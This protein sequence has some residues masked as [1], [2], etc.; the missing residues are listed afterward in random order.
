MEFIFF[1]YSLRYILHPSGSLLHLQQSEKQYCVYGYLCSIEC[2][3]CICYDSFAFSFCS[4]C[5]CMCCHRNQ[6]AFWSFFREHNLIFQKRWEIGKR[7]KSKKKKVAHRIE[8][9]INPYNMLFYE[10]I[11]LPWSN[12][13]SWSIFIT[14]RCTVIKISR[15]E[16]HYRWL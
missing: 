4:C 1:W 13:R 10:Y 2:I 7:K 14:L 8:H 9:W 5:M 12:G 11:R 16:I 3:F 6:L 15:T